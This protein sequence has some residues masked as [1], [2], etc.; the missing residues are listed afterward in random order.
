MCHLNRTAYYTAY[1]QVYRQDYQT[2]YK[3]CRGWSQLNGE[4]GCLYRKC[5]PTFPSR[6]PRLRNHFPPMQGRFLRGRISPPDSVEIKASN[7]KVVFFFV[8]RDGSTEVKRCSP[9]RPPC[10]CYQSMPCPR[11]VATHALC[12]DVGTVGGKK[13]E[14]DSKR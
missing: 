8:L 6:P 3:C 10:R 4:A 11:V 1:R 13:A 9:C 5:H 12:L 7:T 2:V 14:E